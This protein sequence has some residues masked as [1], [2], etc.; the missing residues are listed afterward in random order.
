MDVKLSAR[1]KHASS[2]RGRARHSKPK[3]SLKSVPR[4]QQHSASD[5]AIRQRDATQLPSNWSRYEDEDALETQSSTDLPAVKSKGADYRE[6][7]SQKSSTPIYETSDFVTGR[8]SLMRTRG[9]DLLDWGLDVDSLWNK[10]ETADE[11]SFLSLDIDFLGDA[12]AKVNLAERLFIDPKFIADEERRESIVVDCED[13]AA[14]AEDENRHTPESSVSY[15]GCTSLGNYI[16]ALSSA[17]KFCGSNSC[18]Q[19]TPISEACDELDDILSTKVRDMCWSEQPQRSASTSLVEPANTLTYSL[20]NNEIGTCLQETRLQSQRSVNMT[21]EAKPAEAELHELDDLLSKKVI[22]KSLNDQPQR[23]AAASSMESANILTYSLQN[24][25]TGT[26]LTETRMQSDISV[27]TIFEPKAAEAELDALLD[28]L[29]SNNLGASATI[30]SSMLPGSVHSQGSTSRE[31]VY[32]GMPLKENAFYLSGEGLF[33][34]SVN[35]S[36]RSLDESFVHSNEGFKMGVMSSDVPPGQTL[37][38]PIRV[39]GKKPLGLTEDFDE[40]LDSL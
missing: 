38:L 15:A 19:E 22:D 10:Q 18:P 26:Y 34:T 35:P 12:L 29:D 27:N 9:L 16:T 23:L 2:Q 4:H 20:Q 11:A 3:H 37:S 40:W 7:L 25:E 32:T 5:D 30:T 21:F 28:M 13:T 36:L 24:N 6:L 33:D 39:D 31:A 1:S 17:S 14:E 8:S